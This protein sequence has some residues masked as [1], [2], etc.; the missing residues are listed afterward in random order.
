MQKYKFS[1]LEKV[2]FFLL[3]YFLFI[4]YLELS[5]N[6]VTAK[7]CWKQSF[8]SILCRKFSLKDIYVLVFHTHT[9]VST[10]KSS[11]IWIY[12][13]KCCRYIVYIADIAG[14]SHDSF[15][16][17]LAIYIKIIYIITCN[18]INSF[19]FSERLYQR[20]LFLLNSNGVTVCKYL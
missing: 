4:Y 12:L 13:C 14:E 18:N 3:V 11:Y 15:D 10:Y 17:R 1:M 7:C 9:H 8:T 2:M 6:D 5:I 19:S 16:W 20:F